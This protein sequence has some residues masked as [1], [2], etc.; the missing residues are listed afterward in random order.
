MILLRG[1][2]S[3]GE[4]YSGLV[5]WPIVAMRGWDDDAG[6]GWPEE[7]V[8]LAWW[9]EGGAGMG[10]VG[11]RRDGQQ[12]MTQHTL[13]R[14]AQPLHLHPHEPIPPTTHFARPDP[15]WGRGRGPS[16]TIAHIG[17][18]A[19]SSSYPPPLPFPSPTSRFAHS[20][21]DPV[22]SGSTPIHFPTCPL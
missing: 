1:C 14:P 10:C 17:A 13:L 7:A 6:R 3:H 16:P 22:A 5:A 12:H 21:S 20:W 15:P 9:E 11:M 2:S 19:P 18:G 8:Y 4:G